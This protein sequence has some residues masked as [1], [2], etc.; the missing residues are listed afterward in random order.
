VK[1]KWLS[2]DFNEVCTNA[3]CDCVADF[4]PCVNWPQICVH[5]E[6]A[7]GGTTSSDLANGSTAACSATFP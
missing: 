7:D 4:C 6:E 5:S 3:D 2:D 1:C